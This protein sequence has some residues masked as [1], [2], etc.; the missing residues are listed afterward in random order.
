[1]INLRIPRYLQQYKRR[2]RVK[3]NT[4]A[5]ERRITATRPAQNA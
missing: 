5:A 2:A 4:V 1:M 3:P